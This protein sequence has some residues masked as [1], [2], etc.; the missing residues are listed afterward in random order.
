MHAL[1]ARQGKARDHRQGKFCLDFTGDLKILIREY[2][3]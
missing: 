2:D 3:A 1:E